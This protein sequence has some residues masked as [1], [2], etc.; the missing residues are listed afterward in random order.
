MSKVINVLTHIASDAML[1]NQDSLAKMLIKAEISQKQKNAIIAKDID[2]LIDSIHDL[3]NIK[4]VP[5]I[6]PEVGEHDTSV[7]N[8]TAVNL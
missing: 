7:I 3:P 2:A 4:C 5:I 8:R 6:L 1:I